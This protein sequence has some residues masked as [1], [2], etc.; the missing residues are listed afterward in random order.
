MVAS[1]QM[2]F[3]DLLLKSE[4]QTD[5]FSVR[6]VYKNVMNCT[7]CVDI[8]MTSIQYRKKPQGQALN[9]RM[10]PTFDGKG[11]GSSTSVVDS[12]L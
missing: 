8:C 6:T 11:Y 3:I 2:F 5:T 12:A 10:G 1:A 4:P 9:V 7:V